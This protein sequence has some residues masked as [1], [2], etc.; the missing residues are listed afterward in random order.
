MLHRLRSKAKPFSKLNIKN[1]TYFE[2]NRLLLQVISA[3]QRP[4][5]RKPSCAERA[6]AF[7]GVGA[8]GSRYWTILLGRTNWWDKLAD[9]AVNTAPTE[10]EMNDEEA[11]ESLDDIPDVDAED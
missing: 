6:W 7:P 9:I 8:D 11:A 2:D 1:L 4:G 5:E 3:F 10:D